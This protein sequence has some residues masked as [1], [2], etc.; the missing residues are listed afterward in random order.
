MSTTT[1]QSEAVSLLTPQPPIKS[2]LSFEG[3]RPIHQTP[4]FT[5]KYA[6]R[7]WAKEQMAGAFR[8]FARLG[9]AD[10][11]A[12]HISLRGIL[13]DPDMVLE[14]DEKYPDPVHPDLFWISEFLSS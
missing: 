11:T 6:E 4:T 13:I 14:I 2:V 12:G 8:V 3:G 1:T 10:G 9:W 7:R 5:D